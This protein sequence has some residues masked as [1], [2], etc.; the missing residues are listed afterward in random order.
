MVSDKFNIIVAETS[1]SMTFS[2]Y[3]DGV[4]EHFKHMARIWD[5]PKQHPQRSHHD[6]KFRD[7]HGSHDMCY[8]MVFE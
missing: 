3:E 5:N 4:T 2:D 8:D 1:L 6:N 7:D